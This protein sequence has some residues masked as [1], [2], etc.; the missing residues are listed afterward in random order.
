M[1]GHQDAVTGEGQ[2]MDGTALSGSG[3]EAEIGT[4]SHKATKRRRRPIG[5]RSLNSHIGLQIGGLSIV[6]RCG[7]AGR[8]FQDNLDRIWSGPPTRGMVKRQLTELRDLTLAS[9]NHLFANH[10]D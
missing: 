2:G 9:S 1:R 7:K 8:V 3:P 6:S 5:L 4:R 10:P